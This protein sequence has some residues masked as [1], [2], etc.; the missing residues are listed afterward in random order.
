MTTKNKNRLL[1]LAIGFNIA[2]A[3]STFITGY[4]AS[5]T[6]HITLVILL[7]TMIERQED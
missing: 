2:A 5:L 3:I 6:T 1:G 4:T 7:L